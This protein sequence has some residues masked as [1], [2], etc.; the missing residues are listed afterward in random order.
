[1]ITL[2]NPLTTEERLSVTRLINHD[3]ESDMLA[4]LH[5]GI[6]NHLEH[7]VPIRNTLLNHTFSLYHFLHTIKFLSLNSKY[8]VKENSIFKNLDSNGLNQYVENL[9]F[10]HEGL[11][12]PKKENFITCLLACD[13]LYCM[14]H[15]LSKNAI[16][17]NSRTPIVKKG[18]NQFY[19][20]NPID[21]IVE[22]SSF[23]KNPT[24]APEGC[25]DYDQ[26]LA[27]KVKDTG[28]GFPQEKDWQEYFTTCPE[29]G[30][31]GFGLYFTGLVAKVLRAPV[32]I[33]SEP[34][35]TE[36]TFYHPMYP[37]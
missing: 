19:K 37:E 25:T 3:I 26:F 13:F 36:V 35:N 31:H 33:E 21:L 7:H 2:T 15:N 27:F 17:Y 5:M 10:H 29:K 34:G 18:D 14:L 30:K 16:I 22:E 1:M 11:I 20:T 23:P 12:K 8:D 6:S 24:F 32:K 9:N 4:N 28:K